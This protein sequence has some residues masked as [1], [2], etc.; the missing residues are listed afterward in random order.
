MQTGTIA[1]ILLGLVFFIALLGV[2]AYFYKV[3]MILV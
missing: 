3:K 1:G 2:A